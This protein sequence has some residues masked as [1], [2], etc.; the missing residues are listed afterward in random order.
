MQWETPFRAQG[1][2]RQE[3]AGPRFVPQQI[4]TS[5][6][7][8]LSSL[9]ARSTERWRNYENGRGVSVQD[10]IWLLTLRC[11]LASLRMTSELVS[12]ADGEETGVGVSRQ[13]FLIRLPSPGQQKELAIDQLNN[14]PIGFDFDNVC[15]KPAGAVHILFCWKFL[16]GYVSKRIWTFFSNPFRGV[17][18]H[19]G[20][21]NEAVWAPLHSSSD[22][23][24]FQP[25]QTG[26]GSVHSISAWCK[27]CP[28]FFCSIVQLLMLNGCH[29]IAT[30]TN[31]S[32]MG[33]EGRQAF[34]GAEFKTVASET[35]FAFALKLTGS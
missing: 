2:K 35:S 6:G 8:F 27:N 28:R 7:Y 5:L 18:R 17:G 14:T 29:S 25:F 30:S 21:W 33:E 34:L 12:L 20:S 31:C 16:K 10:S 13:D 9:N 23:Q 32:G 26:W 11:F 1:D 19:D 15:I 3:A 22:P 24:M 4:S